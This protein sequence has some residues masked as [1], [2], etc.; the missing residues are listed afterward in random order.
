M[1]TMQRFFKM[2][3]VERAKYPS[4]MG[5][6]WTEEETLELLKEVRRS[7]THEEIAKKHER[8]LGA[9]IAK[10]RGLAADY[11]Y[12]ENRPIEQISKITGLD[13]DDILL[14]IERRNIQNRNKE[15]KQL[16]NKVNKIQIIEP[17]PT[18][19][20]ISVLK[21]IRDLMRE[22]IELQKAK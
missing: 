18:E 20:V 15:K 21:D 9:I 4:R 17:K 11:H 6:A 7:E 13:K 10:L 8:T 2:S 3:D 19:T 5:Q 12:Y 1:V 14:C 22:Y 16:T